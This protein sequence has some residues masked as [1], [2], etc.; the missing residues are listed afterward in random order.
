M[1]FWGSLLKSSDSWNRLGTLV[2]RVYQAFLT[3][4][5]IK[6]DKIVQE[7]LFEHIVF[8]LPDSKILPL[9]V[10]Y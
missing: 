8:L 10:P 1:S 4:D 6:A 7:L 2:W 3:R 9:A 5:L